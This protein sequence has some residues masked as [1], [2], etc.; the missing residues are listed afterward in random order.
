MDLSN[1]SPD[2][3]QLLRFLARGL[4][5]REIGSRLVIAE[6]EAKALVHE[7]IR[8]L[9]LHERS[10]AVI[11]AYECGLVTPT[12]APPQVVRALLGGGFPDHI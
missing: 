5:D 7:L 4:S 6:A 8:T 10:R 1:L 9:G 11:F 12:A 3:R 2:Q